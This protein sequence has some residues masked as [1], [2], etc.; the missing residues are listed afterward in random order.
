MARK[1]AVTEPQEEQM[2]DAAPMEGMAFEGNEPAPDAPMD[3]GDAAPGDFP[4]DGDMPFGAAAADEGA[5]QTMEPGAPR[6]KRVFP[7]GWGG[8]HG[9]CPRRARWGG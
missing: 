4:D 9:R 1:K 8:R 3:S 2:Q 5:P 7:G 6:P